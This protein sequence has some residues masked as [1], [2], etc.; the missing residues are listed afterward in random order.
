MNTIRVICVLLAGLML[1]SCDDDA[2]QQVREV[3][4]TYMSAV[5]KG[6]GAAVVEMI[7][8]RYI[9]NYEHILKMARKG[10]AKE[11]FRMRPSERSEIVALRN[12]FGKEELRTIDAKSALK[13][14]IDRGG[15]NI[16]NLAFT[17]EDITLRKP[18]A[19]GTLY[20]LGFKTTARMEFVMV[21]EQ[22]K[23]DPECLSRTVDE[24]IVRRS[25]QWGLTED[26]IILDQESTA[27]GKRVSGSI[28]DPPL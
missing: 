1:G 21:N 12:R 14:M 17:L 22:W 13:T 10:T 26:R 2:R 18:R 6:D 8:E 16:W 27:S 20:L 5:A 28:W 19:T 9:E 4:D 7:D 24:E 25:S 15:G 3:F 11:I 23:L